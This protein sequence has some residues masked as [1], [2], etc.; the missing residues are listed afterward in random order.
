M[1]E[2]LKNLTP[3]ELVIW[4]AF[5]AL[6]LFQI[7]YF[8]II[9][10]KL[11]FK[12]SVVRAKNTSYLPP[13]SV[14]ICAK[15]EENNLRNFLPKVLEQDYP[16][17]EVIVINDCSEDDSIDVLEELSQ[18]YPHL[19]ISNVKKDPIYRHG[20]KLALVLGIKAAKYNNIVLT[21][22]DCYPTS[23]KWLRSMAQHYSNK[24]QLILGI[25]PYE[26]G[27]GLLGQVIGYE[28]LLTSIAYISSAMRGKA[29][30]GV[31]RNM[32]YTKDLF[33]KNKGFSGHTHI[34]AGDDDIFVT[35]AATRDNVTVEISAESIVKTLPKT[36]W[37]DFF[38]QKHH[39]LSTC[40]FYKKRPKL[41][42]IFETIIGVL[43]VSAFITLLAAKSYPLIA[44]GVYLLRYII[45]CTYRS[46]AAKK[47][48]LGQKY[49]FQGLW[50]EIIVP[51]IRFTIIVINLFKVKRRYT[52]R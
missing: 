47:M 42:F 32:A 6:L 22:A 18:K 29:Y 27:K 13:I 36:Y 45:I 1:L 38:K 9:Y 21:D 3:F 30:K 24:T 7:F 25:S 20:K 33:Y 5:A 41:K 2:F 10:R 26:K 50:L 51:I 46:I 16:K 15:N 39:H 14:V 28:N 43:F 49:I 4:A 37:S 31:G 23:D 52:W 17:F 12:K 8:L 44:I 35:K 11:L 19:Y 48:N 40:R 34:L